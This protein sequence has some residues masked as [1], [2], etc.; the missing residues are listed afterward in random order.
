VSDNLENNNLIARWLEGDL[1]DEERRSLESSDELNDLNEV[2]KDVSNWKVKS[3]DA[4]SGYEEL[5]SQLTAESETLSRK[6]VIPL[7]SVL[8]YVAAAVLLFLA[9]FGIQKF[10]P[11]S[12]ISYVL[13]PGE[14]HNI[15]L[16]DGSNVHLDASSTLSFNAQR[17]PE[18]RSLSL[19]GQAFFEVTKG[20]S[21][22]VTTQKGL[23]KVLGTEFNIKSSINSLVVAC[24]GGSVLVTESEASH[25]LKQGEGI[26]ISESGIETFKTKEPAPS[27]T[28]SNGGAVRYD[29]APLQE[30]MDDLERQY[31]LKAKLPEAYQTLEFS[32]NVPR[33]NF[34]RALKTI[35]VPM[36]I[37]YSLNDGQVQFIP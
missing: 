9:Y 10:L 17:W 6:K 23:V 28:R 35:F 30:V 7:N 5:K 15:E 33:D 14:T 25:T 18:E 4:V 27:W 34:E 26:R 20:S 11:S 19:E 32:G 36:E 29:Q 16:P 21:F 24:Y 37:S 22:V 13:G 3:F 1:S 8:R 31:G 12:E 2:L